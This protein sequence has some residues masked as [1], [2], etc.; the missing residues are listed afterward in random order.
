MDRIASDSLT[1]PLF[2]PF[3]DV[4]VMAGVSYKSCDSKILKAA[5]KFQWHVV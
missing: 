3:H 5:H 4:C 1:E 2:R